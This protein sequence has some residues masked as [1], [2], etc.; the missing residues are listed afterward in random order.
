MGTVGNNISAENAYF[1]DTFLQGDEKEHIDN[2]CN[3]LKTEKIRHIPFL[4]TLSTAKRAQIFALATKELVKEKKLRSLTSVWQLKALIGS[5]SIDQERYGGL[6]DKFDPSLKVFLADILNVMVEMNQ[7]TDEEML[8]V[9]ASIGVL[10]NSIEDCH[11]ER[12]LELERDDDEMS[13]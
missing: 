5:S 3:S 8:V 11:R 10:L 6:Y 9:E 12:F 7:F 2:L 4:A 13:R 1:R